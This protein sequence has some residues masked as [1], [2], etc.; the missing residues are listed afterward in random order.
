MMKK[1]T[2]ALLIIAAILVVIGGIIGGTGFAMGAST[3]IAVSRK[4]LYIPNHERV[5]LVGV[6]LEDFTSIVSDVSYSNIK[7]IESDTNAF[8]MVY[9]DKNNVPQISVT[10]GVLKIKAAGDNAV[11][12]LNFGVYDE[13]EQKSIIIYYKK[14]AQFQN[15]DMDFDFSH[16]DLG[17]LSCTTK[18]NIKTN[19]GSLIADGLTL[20]VANIENWYSDLYLKNVTANSLTINSEYG[21]ISIDGLTANTYKLTSAFA[22]LNFNGVKINDSSNFELNYGELDLTGELLGN[23][24]FNSSF[25][26][27]TLDLKGADYSYS[28]TQEFSDLSVNG[29]ELSDEGLS[30]K[31][32][33]DNSS[34]NHIDMALNYGDVSLSYN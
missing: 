27:I 12:I 17:N 2:K 25:A 18:A 7:F 11:T 8:D 5:E 16:I 24:S 1:R 28:I 30:S 3:S 23:S 34:T 20:P 26:D 13:E 21:E 14:D 19:Y 32:Q 31:L 15:L 33:S 4:G 10:N 22:D 29:Q 6:P 9:Y